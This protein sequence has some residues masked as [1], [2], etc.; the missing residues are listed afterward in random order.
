MFEMFNINNNLKQHYEEIMLLRKE[1]KAIVKSLIDIEK[2]CPNIRDVFMSISEKEFLIEETTKNIDRLNRKLTI[3]EKDI[4]FENYDY[5]KGL[6]SDYLVDIGISIISSKNLILTLN[7][8]IIGAK[9]LLINENILVSYTSLLSNL[10]CIKDKIYSVYVCMGLNEKHSTDYSD[11]CDHS[12][13]IFLRY[14]DELDYHSSKKSIVVKCLI[15]GE[16]HFISKNMKEDTY[17]IPSNLDEL[18][19]YNLYCYCLVNNLNINNMILTNNLPE[20]ITYKM[21][22]YVRK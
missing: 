5:S 6:T 17:S 4:D 18:S 20:E 2:I 19:F 1:E 13:N 11:K 3:Y 12:N 10:K 9:K 16:I 7:K 15:C 21:P 22:I 8:D 14:D